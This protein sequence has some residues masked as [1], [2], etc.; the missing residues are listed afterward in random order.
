MP[1]REV[2]VVED[3]GVLEGVGGEAG[4]GGEE[5]DGGE[6]EVDEGEARRPAQR[7]AEVGGGGQVVERLLRDTQGGLERRRAEKSKFVPVTACIHTVATSTAQR[8]HPAPLLRPCCCCCS[9]VVVVVVL[10]SATAMAMAHSG[11]G[12]GGLGCK[13]QWT[14]AVPR[15]MEPPHDLA[16]SP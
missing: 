13:L 3:E 8:R 5:E 4:G 1:T 11:S 12:G 9:S 14:A 15:M 2:E 10:T 16:F 7:L 6:G